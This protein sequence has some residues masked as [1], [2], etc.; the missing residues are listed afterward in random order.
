MELQ[1]I[2]LIVFGVIITVMLLV[3]IYVLYYRDPAPPPVYQRGL[4]HE[5]V[6]I[7]ADPSR[8]VLPPKKVRR[9]TV[10]T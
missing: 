1:S 10:I 9:G 8:T 2:L 7:L 5:S 4:P 3:I 6:R